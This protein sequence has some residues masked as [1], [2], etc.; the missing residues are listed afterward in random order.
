MTG[1]QRIE[2]AIRSPKTPGP[3]LV[4][5]VTAGYPSLEA[6]PAVL[7]AACAVADVVEIGIPFSDPM[8]DGVTLQ[9]AARVAIAGGFKLKWLREL[10]Q[11]CGPSTTPLLVMSYTNPLMQYGYPR[12]VADFPV[13][14]WIVPDLPLEEA[15]ELRG[16]ATAH[17]QALVQLVAPN[18]PP[19][20][21]AELAHASSGFLYAVTVTGITGAAMGADVNDYLR[22]VKAVSPLPVCAGF[23]VRTRDTVRRLGEA[24]DGVIVGTALMD[25]L[26][27]GEDVTAF[28]RGLREDT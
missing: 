26:S 12:L 16:L 20:R 21:I 9:A 2:A 19:A 8:A 17:G 11:S 10:L 5:Y 13:D 18:T 7:D 24:A 3:A 6:F 28:L 14:G 4:A 1:A 27:K 22:R 25:A 15:G 23:G